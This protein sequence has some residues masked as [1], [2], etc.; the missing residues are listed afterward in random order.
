MNYLPETQT[1]FAKISASCRW[2]EVSGAADVV[3]LRANRRTRAP[4]P[5]WW[6]RSRATST[7]ATTTSRS[8][9]AASW[10]PSRRSAPARRRRRSPARPPSVSRLRRRAAAALPLRR[11]RRGG[12]CAR[13]R[14]PV[15]RLHA[16]RGCRAVLCVARIAIFTGDHFARQPHCSVQ[17]GMLS[18]SALYIRRL[19]PWTGT[20]ECSEARGA[21]SQ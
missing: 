3:T 10:A 17:R 4:T 18:L 20:R 14:A 12:R 5:S 11:R 16:G 15:T 2:S 21:L 8:G 9:A 7:T 13:W 19:V 6:S 1:I